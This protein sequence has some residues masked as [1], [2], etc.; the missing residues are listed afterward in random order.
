MD[1][2]WY[3]RHE[4]Q[5]SDPVSIEE[6]RQLIASD[7]LC[8]ED[9]VC[10]NGMDA[11]A[12]I[13]QVEG[14]FLPPPL[15]SERQAGGT[16]AGSL[17]VANSGRVAPEL[18]P[19]ALA[20][21]NSVKSPGQPDAVIVAEVVNEPVRL[22]AGAQESARP[23]L[24][25]PHYRTPKKKPGMK[26]TV[27]I[28]GCGLFLLGLVS[29]ALL[30]GT[31]GK[32]SGSGGSSVSHPSLGERPNV[33]TNSSSPKLTTAREPTHDWK[34]STP[35]SSGK[36]L[37]DFG[38][39]PR[40][41]SPPDRNL[42][43]RPAPVSQSSPSP[44]TATTLID[45]GK[46][47]ANATEQL[48][49]EKAAEDAKAA[50]ENDRQ[51]ARDVVEEVLQ[52]LPTVMKATITG[53][54]NVVPLFEGVVQFDYDVKV[55]AEVEQYE[56]FQKKLIAALEKAAFRKG[57][58]TTHGERVS[59]S[60]W[61]GCFYAPY[62]FREKM[63]DSELA[64][65]I[66]PPTKTGDA[67]PLVQPPAQRSDDPRAECLRFLENRDLTQCSG[68]SES[69]RLRAFPGDPDI[70]IGTSLCR[71]IV[72]TARNQDGTELTWKWFIVSQR[73]G[74]H[75]G[76][77]PILRIVLLDKGR[78]QVDMDKISFDFPGNDQ[79]VGFWNAGYESI[80]SPYWI[81]INPGD[82]TPDSGAYL[83]YC[84]DVT[85]HHTM[86]ISSAA[87]KSIAGI[88]CI[89]PT[90]KNHNDFFTDY[91]TDK[92]SENRRDTQFF[93]PAYAAI[94]PGMTYAEVERFF[95]RRA[96]DRRQDSF[97][98][99]KNS[100]LEELSWCDKDRAFVISFK[101]VVGDEHFRVTEKKEDTGFRA[102]YGRVRTKMTDKEVEQ[103]FG[104]PPSDIVGTALVPAD[105]SRGGIVVTGTKKL[106]WRESRGT[107]TISLDK[108]NGGVFRVTWKSQELPF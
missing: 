4:G 33:A 85:I 88:S 103:L 25:L 2:R 58:F 49:N 32:P 105:G 12:P 50:Q 96:D 69:M 74:I 91:R 75:L 40:D 92:S 26:A 104:T 66:E 64:P 16:A 48:R 15:P 45:G 46:L 7:K 9:L 94:K 72:N 36:S 8:A 22:R 63:R 28:G 98:G 76:R 27:V 18:Q 101:K 52:T 37:N 81:D 39:T 55:E 1:E 102:A 67:Q 3:Y 82:R 56:L 93:Q 87:L 106:V 71:F 29:V 13:G 23:R 95:G 73:L 31:S 107:F 53:K 19:S 79:F 5:P 44:Q 97:Y 21:E 43:P 11:W 14:L 17:R 51:S 89:I 65:S 24:G 108:D 20:Q 61:T 41:V 84:V 60:G 42:N 30:S 83:R 70:K 59:P 35:L 90:Y 99:G 34:Q 86:R 38:A 47:A 80:V 62:V 54:P 77:T 78:K 68:H 57:E 10:R 6:L 100:Y